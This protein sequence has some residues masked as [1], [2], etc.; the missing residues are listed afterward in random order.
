[1]EGL[2]ILIFVGVLITAYRFRERL[3]QE[4][5]DA[6]LI[7]RKPRVFMRSRRYK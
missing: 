6:G 2:A 1:M 7:Q 4:W 5:I 3:V